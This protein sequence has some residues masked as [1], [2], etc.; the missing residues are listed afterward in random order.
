MN[1]NGRINHLLHES[2]L[3]VDAAEH[4]AFRRSYRLIYYTLRGLN[5]NR[6]VVDCAA[7][8]LFSMLAVVPLLAVVLIVL[9]RLGVIDAGIKAL[10]TSVPEWSDLLDSVIPAARA[11]VSISALLLISMEESTS[12]WQ[13]CWQKSWKNLIPCS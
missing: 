2:L 1:I 6:T 11:A 9:G 5:I 13:R 4:S 8:T 12:L 3:S 10:Y 7:L